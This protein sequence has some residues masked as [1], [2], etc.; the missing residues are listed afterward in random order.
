MATI[1]AEVVVV[2]IVKFDQTNDHIPTPT[3]YVKKMAAIWFLDDAGKVYVTFTQRKTELY[4]S[5]KEGVGDGNVF[6]LSGNVK[7]VRMPDEHA[8]IERTVITFAKIGG[9]KGK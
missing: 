8:N 7:E 9:Y 6:V 1:R 5:L 4:Q 2:D 3:P